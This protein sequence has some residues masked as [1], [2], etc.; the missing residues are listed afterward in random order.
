MDDDCFPFLTLPAELRNR[1]YNLVLTV[2]GCIRPSADKPSS[3]PKNVPN[4]R[5]VTAA[6][7]SALGLLAVNKQ[8]NSESL[9]IF[10]HRN[11]FEFTYPIQLHA[12]LLNIGSLRLAYLRDITVYYQN[13]K[14]GGINLA[15]LTFPMLKQLSGLRRLQVIM[16]LDLF[17]GIRRP[18]WWT[19]HSGWEL[20][21]RANPIA[22]PGLKVLFT[23][24][25]ITD[26]KVRDLRLEQD[27]EEAKKDKEYP[28][29]S[30]KSR[31][32]CVVKLAEVLERFNVALANA[33]QGCLDKKILED[34]EWHLKESS[35]ASVTD[36]GVEEE[37]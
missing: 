16:N 29:F 21:D 36:D 9:G 31:S 4:R 20:S 22:L 8:I 32:A 10:Y 25:G 6:P 14:S 1:V 19:N 35:R 11:S 2:P 23:L 26:I 5:V 30:V 37:E 27:V 17:R 15:E 24:R 12:F 7:E 28:T 3:T 13:S 34:P 18:Q 33:Q